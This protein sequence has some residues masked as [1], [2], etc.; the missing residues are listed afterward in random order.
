LFGVCTVDLVSAGGGTLSVGTAISAA[1]L[2]AQT[3]ATNIDA[4]EIWHD[5][6]PDASVELSSVASEKIITQNIIET[7]GTADITAG[8][9]YYICSWYP[10]SPDGNVASAI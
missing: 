3:T 10:L 9:I 1:G 4:G 5:N 8:N 7:V 2:I 6:S